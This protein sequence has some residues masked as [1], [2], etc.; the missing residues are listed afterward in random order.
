MA[1]GETDLSGAMV[2]STRFGFQT[3]EDDGFDIDKD[4]E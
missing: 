3:C 1:G 4:D 2:T